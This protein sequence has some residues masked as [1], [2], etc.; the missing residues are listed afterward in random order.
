[1]AHREQRDTPVGDSVLAIVGAFTNG[2]DVF[3]RLR[4]RRRR[5][6]STKKPHRATPAQIEPSGDEL[7]LS[8][9]LR[10]NPVDIQRH[11]E[12]NYAA[13][14]EKFAQGDGTMLV[15]P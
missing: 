4:E 1:M 2:L 14:G 6:K 3:K 8:N 7:Q 11:Y 5:R 15:H 10:Q 13:V 12:T 9:S